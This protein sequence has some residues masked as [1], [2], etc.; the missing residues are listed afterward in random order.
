MSAGCVNV[1]AA[2][3][4]C[5]VFVV[6]SRSQEF[7]LITSKEKKRVCTK[8][9]HWNSESMSI[10]T[11]ANNRQQQ[12]T[13]PRYNW[14]SGY[15]RIYKC[16][17]RSSICIEVSLHCGWYIYIYI[18][19]YVVVGPLIPLQICLWADHLYMYVLILVNLLYIQKKGGGGEVVRSQPTISCVLYCTPDNSII[20]PLHRSTTTLKHLTALVWSIM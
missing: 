10:K 16:L 13:W 19:I 7:S 17:T 12:Q 8:I 5:W 2:F 3:T 14:I 6:I 11:L 18:Y 20:H 9:S 4:A 1:S 15:N